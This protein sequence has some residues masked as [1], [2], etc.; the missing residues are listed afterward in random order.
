MLDSM[1][2]NYNLKIRKETYSFTNAIFDHPSDLSSSMTSSF[3]K[4]NS[5]LVSS[6]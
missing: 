2:L 1:L 6:S 5:A 3:S 4:G